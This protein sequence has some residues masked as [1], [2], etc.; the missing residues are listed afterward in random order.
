[1]RPVDRDNDL[2]D[3]LA[4]VADR[5]DASRS[6]PSDAVLAEVRSRFMPAPR[7]RGPGLMRTRVAIATMLVLGLLISGTGGAL[8]LSG[9]SGAG[10]ATTNDVQPQVLGTET[11]PT[12]A[13]SPTE[14]TSPQVLGEQ[15]PAAPGAAQPAPQA[16][17]G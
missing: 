15:T 16:A 10:I 12:T 8:A 6:E 4:A 2:P 1:M 9:E 17:A 7:R 14:S 11:S 3:Q 5:L 13:T